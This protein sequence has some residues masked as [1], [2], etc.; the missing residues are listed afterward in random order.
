LGERRVRNAEVGSSSLLPSTKIRPQKRDSF[1]CL[2]FC[3]CLMV[4]KCLP[5]VIA[6]CA[7]SSACL[8]RDR[9]NSSCRWAGD[10]AGIA[11][12]QHLAADV[13]LAEELAIRFAD[14]TRGLR[15][16]QFAG[17]QVYA[18]TRDECMTSLLATIGTAHGV[19]PASLRQM[20]GR[21]PRGFDAA[22]FVSFAMLYVAACV[23]GSRWLRRRFRSSAAPFTAAAV[24]VSSLLA[25]LVAL[26]LLE[27]WGSAWEMLRLG[28]G[29]L[30]YRA[31]REPWAQSG[32]EMFAIGVVVFLG[33]AVH[34]FRAA[35]SA[36]CDRP[37]EA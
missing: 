4:L 18:D 8:P 14:T 17:T 29:H 27:L 25:S 37:N 9:L 16:R 3:T 12:E 23:L 31:G 34:C 26:V 13:A 30:S 36:A 6:L 24:I 5:L 2:F 1:G 28:N 11:S 35:P 20:I 32:V 33:V 15:S 19:A 10:V 7:L 22:V 21:R